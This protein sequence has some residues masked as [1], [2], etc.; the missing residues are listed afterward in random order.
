MLRIEFTPDGEYRETH[1]E[2][3]ML[4]DGLEEATLEE[5]VEKFCDF[6]RAIT[7]TDKQVDQIK[8]FDSDSNDTD[9]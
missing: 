7:F 1:A 4:W 9:I 3:S 6:L 5:Y 8:I 2:V